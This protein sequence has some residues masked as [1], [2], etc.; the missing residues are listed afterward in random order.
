MDLYDHIMVPE[1]FF[2]LHVYDA[3]SGKLVD[4]VEGHN[5]VVNDGRE[6]LARLLGNHDPILNPPPSGVTSW[7][8][9][10]LSFG[11][12]GH[13][14][15]NIGDQTI[16]TP[17][18][19]T[20]TDLYGTKHISRPV[21][22]SWPSYRKVVFEATVESTEGNHPSPPAVNEYSEAG[23]FYGDTPGTSTVMFAHKSFGYVV[24]NETIR[25]VATWTF[26]F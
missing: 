14:P 8:V 9:D 10:T 6:A 11:D 21:T 1:G 26:T 5:I 20:D 2:Q 16:M 25:L 7:Y 24:K 12:G 15:D 13:D 4:Y 17:V 23:L 18:L 22:V 19:V 3:P